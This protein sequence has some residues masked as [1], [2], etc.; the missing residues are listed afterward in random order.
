VSIPRWQSTPKFMTPPTAKRLATQRTCRAEGEIGRAG[1]S[2]FHYHQRSA[3]SLAVWG[4]DRVGNI[5]RDYPRYPDEGD[6]EQAKSPELYMNEIF[7]A[8]IVSR[9]Q[10]ISNGKIR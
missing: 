8:R 2:R 6:A 10:T 4:M 9:L 5:E 3:K 1:R 7:L